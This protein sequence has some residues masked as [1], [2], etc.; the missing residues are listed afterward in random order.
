MSNR[1]PYLQDPCDDAVFLR[2]VVGA[3]AVLCSF[4]RLLQPVERANPASSPCDGL[5]DGRECDAA[6]SLSLRALADMGESGIAKHS[7][8]GCFAV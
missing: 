1:A 5:R 2:A 4:Y 6:L 3:V 8:I 7:G